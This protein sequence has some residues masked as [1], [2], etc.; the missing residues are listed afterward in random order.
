MI[1]Q[2]KQLNKCYDESPDGSTLCTCL[3]IT[4]SACL[5]EEKELHIFDVDRYA[6]SAMYAD[7]C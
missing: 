1:K 4:F 6:S 5:T 3:V 2:Y 7:I